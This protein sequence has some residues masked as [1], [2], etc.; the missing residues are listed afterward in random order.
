MLCA[1]TRPRYQVSVY[2]TI[3]PLVSILSLQVD[4]GSV[5]SVAC[6]PTWHASSPEIKTLLLTHSLLSKV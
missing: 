4:K 2:R 3:G 5:C 6:L 1:Y